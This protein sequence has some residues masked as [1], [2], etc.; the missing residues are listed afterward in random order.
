MCVYVAGKN[1]IQIKMI[2]AYFDSG[3]PLSFN[4]N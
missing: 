3:F 4:P 1:E 2:L